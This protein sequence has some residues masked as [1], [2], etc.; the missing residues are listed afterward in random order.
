MTG[1]RST[2]FHRQTLSPEARSLL[3]LRQANQASRATKPRQQ[4]DQLAMGTPVT[5][6]F[7]GLLVLDVWFA[8]SAANAVETAIE[9][10]S[11]EA[12]AGILE[13]TTRIRDASTGDASAPASNDPG[14]VLTAG[15]VIDAG[16]LASLSGA[17]GQTAILSDADVA[18]TATSISDV[19]AEPAI[20]TGNLALNINTINLP[21]SE[22][23]TSSNDEQLD[24]IGNFERANDGGGVLAGTDQADQL[25]GGAGDDLIN[26]LAGNDRLAGN[27]GNDEIFGGGG[28]DELDGGAGSDRLYGGA[29]NDEIDGGDDADS[30][31][32][33]AGDDRLIGGNG[34][35]I[36]DGGA[37]GDQ[38]HGGA[39]NDRHIVDDFR[40]IPLE[41]SSGFD[42]GGIDTVEVKPGFAQTLQSTLPGLSSDGSASFVIGNNLRELDPN[43]AIF[44][45]T[46]DPD[47]ENIKLEG[48][49]G[50]DLFGNAAANELTG[51]AGDNLIYGGDGADR[52]AG[53]AGDDEIHGDAGDD[54]LAGND[55]NDFLY[56]GAGDDSYMFG[57]NDSA[58]TTV[59][60]HQGS[61][62]IEIDASRTDD[63]RAVVDNGDLVF[64]QNDREFARIERY[65]ESRDAFSDVAF[66]DATVGLDALIETPDEPP[67]PADPVP[68]DDLLADFL[69]GAPAEPTH[70][71]TSGND[72]VNGSDGNDWLSG[73]D[74]NDTLT[75][76]DGDDLLEGGHGS[77]QLRGGAGDDTYVIN[78]GETG[79]DRID[80]QLG[81]NELRLD[82]FDT[83]PIG[84]FMLGGDLW[85]T[86]SNAPVAVINDLDSSGLSKIQAGDRNINV[87]DLA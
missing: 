69:P 65:E 61:N 8:G 26:G 54:W 74:G 44:R 15:A 56:G 22:D 5:A 85:V 49:T 76:L 36:L 45:Q 37:G 57:L 23:D 53:G 9:P 86:A 42:Q 55:G 77:D 67:T 32:G 7:I 21:D 81:Q 30:L 40:D 43:A 3:S 72:F 46:I 38:L 73:G 41:D 16:T 51:N 82:G 59:F 60:D 29:D 25:V 33:E 10:A 79:I 78:K 1:L 12:D 80:D 39:G 52:L 14:S 62:K 84:G 48:E 24:P 83:D 75:G 18:S 58:V 17:A 47:I 64:E 4:N 2:T 27:G 13:T 28:R 63:L 66:T 70:S 11:D 71:G 34:D 31:F 50:H 35:D 68:P 19:A 87:D 6:T 20:V